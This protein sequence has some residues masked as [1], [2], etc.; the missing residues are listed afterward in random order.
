MLASELRDRLVQE[1]I[2]GR[3]PQVVILGQKSWQDLAA[4]LTGKRDAFEPLIFQGV[5]VVTHEQVLTLS[6]PA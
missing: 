2:F 5:M 4:D 1:M 3:R 6:D